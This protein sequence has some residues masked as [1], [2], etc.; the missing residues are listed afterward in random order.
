MSEM[1]RVLLWGLRGQLSQEPEK[2]TMRNVICKI[3][4]NGSV[5]LGHPL[6]KPGQGGHLLITN[7]P[8]TVTE[9]LRTVSLTALTKWLRGWL[10]AVDNPEK[11]PELATYDWSELGAVR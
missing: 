3:M 11:Y 6:A 1:S 2:T 7:V 5:S 9:L 10:D 4:T 8:A